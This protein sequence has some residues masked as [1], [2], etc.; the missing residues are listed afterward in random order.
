M[1]SVR[2]AALALLL[3]TSCAKPPAVQESTRAGDVADV[4][5]GHLLYENACGAC[6]TTQPHWREKHIVHSWDDLTYQV[7]RWQNVA[8]QNW[9]KADIRDVAAY[10]NWRFYHLPCHEKGCAGHEA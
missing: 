3:A 7:G 10:L 4:E 1:R 6:H 5:R 2:L 9:S 8:G